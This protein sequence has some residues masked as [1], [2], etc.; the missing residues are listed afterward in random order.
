MGFGKYLLSIIPLLIFNC[1][2]CNS[3]RNQLTSFDLNKDLL[4]A[5][6]DF[7]TDVDDLHSVAAFGTLI[8]NSK[9]SEM[10]YHAVAGAYGIQTGLYVH[11]NELCHLTFGNNWSDAHKDVDKALLEVKEIALQ[12]LA[13]EGDIWIAEGGQSDFSAALV[14]EIQAEKP[15]LN[16]KERIHIVQHA[17]WNEEVTSYGSLI[18]VK[19][20]T[21]YKKIPDGNAMGNGTPGF[22]SDQMINLEEFI[23]APHLLTIWQLAMELA[24]K[25]NGKEGRYLNESIRSGGLD[26]S[27]FS[28]ICWILGL[29]DIK[30]AE[31]FFM[32]YSDQN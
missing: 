31:E 16:T 1:T 5:H 13:E 14:K 6:Y 26:F 3:S 24:N 8:S 10:N 22:R 25:N 15:A 29:H 20:N 12:I 11:P 23:Q 28:E 21:D 27:D 7:K 2:G 18:F 32:K 9:F 30:N 4:L 19:N 17:D